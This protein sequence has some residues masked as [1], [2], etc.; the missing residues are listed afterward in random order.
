MLEGKIPDP[1]CAEP[2]VLGVLGQNEIFGEDL[3]RN[4]QFCGA[5]IDAFKMLMNQGALK[6]VIDVG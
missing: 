5:I 4:P 3:P 2:Y 6:S 1:A